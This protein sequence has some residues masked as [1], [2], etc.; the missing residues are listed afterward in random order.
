MA[1]CEY[2][3]RW[4]RSLF[5][6]VASLHA[7]LGLVIRRSPH[8]VAYVALTSVGSGPQID[9]VGDGRIASGAVQAQHLIR[10][11]GGVFHEVLSAAQAVLGW[12]GISASCAFPPMDETVADHKC[13]PRACKL[14]ARG[15]YD[16][17]ASDISANELFE[18]AVVSV[19]LFE[20]AARIREH[21]ALPQRTSA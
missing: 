2:A 10:E 9:I 3:E 11:L 18:T 6:D 8:F 5:V 15:R 20:A 19:D 7:Y 21:L 17:T 4:Q 13:M 12:D 14:V 1:S 16:A